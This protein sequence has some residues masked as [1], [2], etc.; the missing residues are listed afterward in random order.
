MDLFSRA[1]ASARAEALRAELERHAHA[2]YVLD[3]PTVSDAEYD[4]LYQEL[5]ALE[6]THPELRRADSPTQRVGGRALERFESVRHAV[7][8]LSIRTETDI[9]EGGALGFDARV[10]RDL[11]LDASDPPVE[12][13]A[14]LK[15]DGLAISLRYEAGVLVRAATRGDGETGEDV[16]QNVRTIGQIPLRLQGASVPEVLEV[17]GEVYMRRDDFERLNT[18]QAEAGEKTFVNPRNAAA[19]AVRQLDPAIARR[20]PLSFFAYGVGEFAGWNMPARQSAIL[21]ALLAF[22]FPV[23]VERTLAHGAEALVAFHRRVGE[24]RGQLP[25][26]IDGVVYKVDRL[27]WQRALGW[28]TREPRWAVAHKYAPQE[29]IT[30]LLGIE[31]QVGRTGALTPVAR[32][33]PVFVGG[34]TVTNASLHN[35]DM[36]R[37]KGIKVGDWVVVRRAGDVIPEVVTAVADR[38]DGSEREFVMPASCPVCGS[39][40]VR[41]EGEAA[42]RCTGGIACRAQ[43]SQAILHFAGRRMM[44]IDG[45]GER[46]IE[47]LVEFGYVRRVADLY[48]L[49]LEDLLEMKRRADARDGVTPETVQQ[50]RI[51][52]KWAENLIEA[53]AASKTPPLARLLFALGI[54]HVGESTAR[55]LADQLGSLDAVRRTPREVFALLPD[56]G[57]IVAD[58]LYEFFSEPNNARVLDELSQAGVHAR[59][60][61]PPANAF[62][63]GLAWPELLARLQIPR[64]TPVRARQ[65]A[66]KLADPLALARTTPGGL[67][68]I[69]LPAE[70][71]TELERWLAD[72]A[73]IARLE[74]LAACLASWAPLMARAT[75]E[76]AEAPG[77]PLAGHIF[78]LTGTLPGLS[79][80][81]AGALIEARGGKVSGSVSRKTHFVV[82]G[83]EA[84]SKLAKAQELGVPVLD[85]AGLRKLL[86]G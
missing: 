61:H 4:R 75:E 55:T 28:V 21:D 83:A 8:M 47:S 62:L 51:A 81:E 84:G 6:A 86:D 17:R 71:A 12:Y 42:T 50:G 43:C 1:D 68:T 45:L 74:A 58:S 52:T 34:V 26:D 18:A 20:R 78:V 32:L 44:D 5:E 46:Y 85:E 53:I 2:Y 77:L 63:A 38:R 14:E 65:L 16:T 70:L 69:G 13:L 67:A 22:G 15:F 79:R 82:A 27:D 10:R 56:I 3:A 35:E 72:A 66:D 39:H 54:R 64:L 24:L 31:I 48:R 29:E 40:A 80:D 23:S 36:I 73:N 30:R 33:E 49:R 41:E 60:E 9:G 7:P 19:G 57:G 76:A 37:H 59:D 25:F 11:D